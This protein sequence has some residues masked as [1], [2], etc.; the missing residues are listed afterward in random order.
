VP[1]ADSVRGKAWWL[2]LVVGLVATAGYYLLPA[3]G[4]A[5]NIAY[6]GIGLVS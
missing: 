2:W 5:R 6:N 1:I 3:G 4:P